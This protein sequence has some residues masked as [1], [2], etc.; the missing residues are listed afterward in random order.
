MHLSSTTSPW[1]K[2]FTSKRYLHP[3]FA[4][5]IVTMWP[6]SMILIGEILGGNGAQR[7]RD[8]MCGES[9]VP[10]AGLMFGVNRPRERTVY[11]PQG[12]QNDMKEGFM[13]QEIVKYVTRKDGVPVHTFVKDFEEFRFYEEAFC[14]TKRIP[15]AYVKVT[16]ENVLSE[17]QTL[18]FGVFVRSG[19]EFELIGCKDPDGYYPFCQTEERWKPLQRFKREKGVLTDGVYRLYFPETEH[20]SQSGLQD[21]SLTLTLSPKEKRTFTF[22]FTRN[23]ETP[24]KYG[25]ARARTLAFWTKELSKAKLRP[26]KKSG[27]PLFNNLTAQNLQM[28]CIPQGENYVLV[29]QGGLQRYIWPTEAK[30]LLVALSKTGGYEDYLQRAF[31]TYFDVLQVKEGENA[32]QVVNFG[33]PWASITGAVL[34]AFSVAAKTDASLY[35]RY[36]ENATLAFRW[37][38]RERR[39]TYGDMNAVK[40]LFPPATSCDYGKDDSQIWGYTDCWLLESYEAFADL[41]KQKN[42]EDY[43]EVHNAYLEYYKSVQAVFDSVA[44]EQEGEGK[45]ELPYDASNV[46]E[47][48]TELDGCYFGLGKQ[49]MVANVLWKGFAGYGTETAKRIYATYYSE[50]SCRSGLH[51]ACYASGT[52]VGK[53]WYTS[54]ADYDL[55]RYFGKCGDVK[56]QKEILDGQLKYGVSNEYYLSERYDDHDAFIAPWCPN[57]SANG[58]LLLMLFDYY[59]AK[60]SFYT[61]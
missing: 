2:F 29:R 49:H 10:S 54:F 61:K 42:S 14:D 3:P 33:I 1:G 16:I 47:K 19:A 34:E 11:A 17:S 55:Y 43:F 6:S 23:G 53:T 51:H 46:A 32:G 57:A 31:A 58:R 8:G 4:E 12:I 41:L 35:D 37:I 44:R 36:I 24:C 38:E 50:K 39:K 21:L 48:E 13:P 20:F 40:G 28:F 60:S 27:D 9:A 7:D 15:T 45:L 56:K 52:G 5:N 26:N 59:G 25:A 22:A 18:R 30:S